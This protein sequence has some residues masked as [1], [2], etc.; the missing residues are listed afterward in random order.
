MNKRLLILSGIAIL[1]VVANHAS[2]RGFVA[3]FWWTDRYL[4]VS[5]PNFD[6]MGSFAYYALVA[7]QKLALFSV[8]AFLFVSGAFIA[9]AARGTQSRLGWPM[10]WKRISNLLPP[11][12]IWVAVYILTDILVIKTEYALQDLILSVVTVSQSPYF[13]VPLL[14][15]F[16]LLSPFLAP[17]AKNHWRWLLG[18]ALLV[19]LVAMV[20][21]YLR[22]FEVQGSWMQGMS[23]LFSNQFAEFIFFYS[24]GMI[25]G[26]RLPDLKQGL[27]KFRWPLLVSTLV[28][29]V[30][31]VVEAEWVFQTYEVDVWRSATL[32]LP[33]FLFILSFIL[34]FFA[35]DHV[36]V[37]FSNFFYGLGVSTLAIYLIHKSI[38]LVL[39]KLVYNFAPF[40]LGYQVLY[41]PLLIATAI[42][43]P[44]LMMNLTKRTPLSQVY[45]ILYG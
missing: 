2:H 36:E 24:L 34:A 5:V 11:Y 13:F 35:F 16:F 38:L 20:R 25:S 32:T 45:R 9:Y 44:V 3:M 30:L 43:I 14:I 21:A 41:Q 8:P 6:Q 10:I 23:L 22:L 12:L 28:F 33:T 37:P 26:F 19:Q 1:A 42:G 31:A 29:A 7:Q 15:V 17:V 4:P 18:A 39:P 27:Y 40:I